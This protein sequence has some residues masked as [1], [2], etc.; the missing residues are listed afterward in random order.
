MYKISPGGRGS[1]ASS[2]P[3][4]IELSNLIGFGYD[5]SDNRDGLKCWRMGFIF[6]GKHPLLL[7]RIQMSNPGPM[8]SHVFNCWCLINSL[9]SETNIILEQ[10]PVLHK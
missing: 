1:I 8:G 4:L 7:T 6:G 5:L 3:N 2:R 10:R 9:I